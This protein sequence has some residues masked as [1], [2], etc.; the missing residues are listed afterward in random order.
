MKSVKLG[1][2][3]LGHDTIYSQPKKNW[4]HVLP[5][6]SVFVSFIFNLRDSIQVTSSSTRYFD[7]LDSL[8]KNTLN[9]TPCLLQTNRSLFGLPTQNIVAHDYE[10]ESNVKR[11]SW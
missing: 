3:M 10:F 4:I 8:Q 2:T 5:I 6:D 9:F 11:A 1:K 7:E